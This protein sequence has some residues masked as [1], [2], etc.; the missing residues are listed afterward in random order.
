MTYAARFVRLS[1]EKKFKR[2][3][4]SLGFVLVGSRPTSDGTI[5]TYKV[6][7]PFGLGAESSDKGKVKKK[8]FAKTG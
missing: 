3:M 1:D 4:K 5:L 8:D 6:D 2:H 7:D